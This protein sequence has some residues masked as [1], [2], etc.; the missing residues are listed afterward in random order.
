MSGME[1]RDL[2]KMLADNRFSTITPLQCYS[3]IEI[4]DVING[5]IQPFVFRQTG[6]GWVEPAL[7][8][9]LEANW[10]I[11]FANRVYVSRFDLDLNMAVSYSRYIA[12]NN[13]AYLQI[14]IPF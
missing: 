4:T 9:P 14:N 10:Q 2:T 5:I 8:S 1:G 6:K 11:W 12:P 7:H 3:P 13:T